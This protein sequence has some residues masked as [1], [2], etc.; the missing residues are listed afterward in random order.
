MGRHKLGILGGFKGKVGTVSG[1]SWKGIEY[2]KGPNRGSSKPATQAQIEA[3]AKFRV[4]I[5][6]LSQLGKLLKLGFKDSA[7]KM[8]GTNSAFQYNYK[9]ALQGLYPHYSLDYTKVLL[10]DGPLQQIVNPKAEAT[11]GGLVKFSWE[12][13]TGIKHA[14]ASDKSILLVYCPEK[15][16][17]AYIDDGASRSSKTASINAGIFNGK[18]VETWLSFI[19]ADEKEVAP[20]IYTGQLTVI[21]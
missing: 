12:D 11:G 16:R 13:N 18:T 15:G 9:N 1:A 4:V 10:T 7:I 20:S 3:R 19:S 8:T 21:A 6:F 17:F 14:N 2:I 5:R